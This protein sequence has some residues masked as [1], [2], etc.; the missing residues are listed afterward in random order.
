MFAY[1]IDLTARSGYRRASRRFK[2]VP[3][4]LFTHLCYCCYTIYTGDVCF[5]QLF[6]WV[7][8][9]SVLQCVW[10][11]TTANAYSTVDHKSKHILYLTTWGLRWLTTWRQILTCCHICSWAC[12]DVVLAEHGFTPTLCMPCP[13]GRHHTFHVAADRCL[14]VNMTMVI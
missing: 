5:E 6:Y 7:P 3:R 2:V 4:Y 13:R 8:Q 9:P 14:S 10:H 12:S 1:M 11:Y